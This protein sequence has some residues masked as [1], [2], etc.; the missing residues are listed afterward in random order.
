MDN[1]WYEYKAMGGITEEKLQELS[2]KDQIRFALFCAN[3]VIGVWSCEPDFVNAIKLVELW[4]EDKAT[5]E[6]CADAARITNNIINRLLDKRD[7]GF[8]VS[9]YY[10]NSLLA[11]DY[12]IYATSNFE[13][14]GIILRASRS[15]ANAAYYASNASPILI[16]YQIDYYNELRFVDENFERIVLEGK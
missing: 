4:L 7:K 3:Q 9:D 12:T 15:C 8:H 16:K 5:V 1:Y 14:L 6:E 10:L 2:N 13:N 11:A